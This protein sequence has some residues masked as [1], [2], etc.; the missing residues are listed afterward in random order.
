MGER[1][2]IIAEVYDEF[3]K[4]GRVHDPADGIEGDDDVALWA[5]VDRRLRERG[6]GED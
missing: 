2:Q 5:E 4:A 6:L 3:A 1:E